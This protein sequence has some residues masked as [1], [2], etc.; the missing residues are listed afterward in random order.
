MP[1]ELCYTH[2]RELLEEMNPGGL[3]LWGFADFNAELDRRE[4]LL[5]RRSPA[6]GDRE[7][8]RD[9]GEGDVGRPGEQ[10]AEGPGDHVHAVEGAELPQEGDHKADD[11]DQH[12]YAHDLI[13][14][15][16][17]RS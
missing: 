3:P 9:A 17:A 1:S 16:G 4:A 14:P 11:G 8:E 10:A 7:G 13:L 15:R 5:G 2:A 12:E 6:L